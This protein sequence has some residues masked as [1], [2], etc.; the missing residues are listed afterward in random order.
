MSEKTRFPGAISKNGPCLRLNIR[1]SK[2]F[3]SQ[4][5]QNTENS[6]QAVNGQKKKSRFF[7]AKKKKKKNLSPQTLP[8]EKCITAL[9]KWSI[10]AP[11]GRPPWPRGSILAPPL[12][13]PWPPPGPGWPGRSS[14]GGPGGSIWGSSWTPWDLLDPGPGT[15]D[16]TQSCSDYVPERSETR[17]LDNSS[18]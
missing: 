3:F 16:R 10:G 14:G 5:R 13:P 9:K 18:R 12:G 4:I 11:P 2:N 6:N 7:G 17:I 8:S 1:I 15:Q